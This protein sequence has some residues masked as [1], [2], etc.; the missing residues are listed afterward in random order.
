MDLQPNMYQE[1]RRGNWPFDSPRNLLR[2]GAKSNRYC[3]SG[4]RKDK[5]MPSSHEKSF[6][7]IRGIFY[8]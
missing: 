5:F 7:F 4:I 2:Q 3:E 6:L 8:L 1:W